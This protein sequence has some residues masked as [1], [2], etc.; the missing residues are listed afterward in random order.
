MSSAEET[1]VDNDALKVRP[2]PFLSKKYHR[3]FDQLDTLAINKASKRGM[4]QRKTRV[5]SNRI[6]A[7]AV[8]LDIPKW[9]LRL[10]DNQLD[11]SGLLS[12]GASP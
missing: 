11:S 7:R 3:M 12:D 5:K 6:S 4:H 1:D 8:P 9:A 10:D 2:L